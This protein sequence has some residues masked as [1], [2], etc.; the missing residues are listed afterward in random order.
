LQFFV[1]RSS[2]FFVDILCGSKPKRPT[3]DFDASSTAEG[4]P[5]YRFGEVIHA[6]PSNGLPEAGFADPMLE[7]NL[8]PQPIAQVGIRRP[9]P[10]QASRAGGSP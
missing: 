8:Q 5:R 6:Q 3:L 2:L 4:V 10:V 7:E 1:V 9:A